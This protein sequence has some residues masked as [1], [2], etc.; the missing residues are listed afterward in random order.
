MDTDRY[1]RLG[2][3]A[4]FMESY[5]PNLERRGAFANDPMMRIAYVSGV[6]NGLLEQGRWANAVTFAFKTTSG[7]F[8]NKTGPEFTKSIVDSATNALDA[9]GQ[10][11]A[12]QTLLDYDRAD[13]VNQLLPHLDVDYDFLVSAARQSWKQSPPEPEHRIAIERKLGEMAVAENLRRIAFDHF[14]EAGATERAQQLYQEMLSDAYTSLENL[15]DITS[16]QPTIGSQQEVYTAAIEQARTIK[17]ES[18]GAGKKLYILLKKAESLG[19]TVADSEELYS[20]AV[21]HMSHYHAEEIDDGSGFTCRL[22]W[23]KVHTKDS[24]RKAYTIFKVLEYEGPEVFESVIAGLAL[25]PFER[26][27]EAITVDSVRQEHLQKSYSL[28]PLT[29]R[30]KIAGELEPSPEN[31]KLKQKLAKELAG[32]NNISSAYSL[33][34]DSKGDPQDKAF[35]EWQDQLINEQIKRST[36]WQIDNNDAQGQKKIWA[37]ALRN[38]NLIAAYNAARHINDVALNIVRTKLVERGPIYALE[39]FNS[40]STRSQRDEVGYALAKNAIATKYNVELSDLEM[41][42]EQKEPIAQ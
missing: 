18:H 20:K 11:E 39:F 1:V 35:N 22:Q 42:L 5:V 27:Y 23:A 16:N 7:S 41:M 4:S 14:I 33:W 30:E 2:R 24:P 37:R 21:Q 36:V 28:A 10:G 8:L 26:K 19:I 3:V 13:I 38:G 25:D 31:N 17:L 40:S 29:V 34:F 6:M 9:H 15:E 12:I 32:V